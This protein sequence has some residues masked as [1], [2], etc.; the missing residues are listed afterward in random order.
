MFNFDSGKPK[1]KHSSNPVVQSHHL[2]R[3]TKNKATKCRDRTVRDAAVRLK[4]VARFSRACKSASFMVWIWSRRLSSAGTWKAWSSQYEQSKYRKIQ[5]RCVMMY[6]A[7]L[8]PRHFNTS[9][10]TF[11][12]RKPTAR[13]HNTFKKEMRCRVFVLDFPFARPI[14][15]FRKDLPVIFVDVGPLGT[16]TRTGS[17]WHSGLHGATRYAGNAPHALRTLCTPFADGFLDV[18]CYINAQLHAFHNAV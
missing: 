6:M 17:W 15:V 9:L 16:V 14:M 8:M 3:Q 4:V 12:G 2:R 5:R 7:Y 18:R 1:S 11:I 10:A 13:Y